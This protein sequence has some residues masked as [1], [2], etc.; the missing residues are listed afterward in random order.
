M[1][2][3]EFVSQLVALSEEMRATSARIVAEQA[4]LTTL[5]TQLDTLVNANKALFVNN[6]VFQKLVDVATAPEA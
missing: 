5:N 4:R 1:E 6:I 2:L 3:K